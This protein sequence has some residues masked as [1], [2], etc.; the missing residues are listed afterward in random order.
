[1]SHSASIAHHSRTIFSHIAH[2]KNTTGE[3]LTRPIVCTTV[4]DVEN[5][6]EPDRYTDWMGGENNSSYG[7]SLISPADDSQRHL[8]Q[9]NA[10]YGSHD[11]R[12]E[13]SGEKVS[14]FVIWEEGDPFYIALH[15]ACNQIAQY[16]IASG[17]TVQ[18]T[19]QM[20]PEDKIS[21]L[22]QLWQVIFARFEG[23]ISDVQYIPPHPTDYYGCDGLFRC[24]YCPED[25]GPELGQVSNAPLQPSSRFSFLIWNSTWKR[26][27]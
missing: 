19:F 24:E 8:R 17:D 27:Q 10:K 2:R 25:D 23:V 6:V 12:L 16:F 18:D 3:W 5:G 21:S 11:F 1:M 9:M 26:T 7:F 14:V 15:E 20:G 4:H 13:T 22:K